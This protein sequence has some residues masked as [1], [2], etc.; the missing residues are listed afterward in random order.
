M[1]QTNIGVAGSPAAL[2]KNLDAVISSTMEKIR[3]KLTDNI[4]TSNAFFHKLMK[5]DQYESYDGGTLISEPL[6]YALADLEAY[7]GYDELVSDPIDGI[8]TA[9][10]PA[11]QVAAPI[12]YNMKE[13]I[14]NKRQIFSLVKAKTT[15]AQMGIEEGFAK[16][17][18]QGSGDGALE[19]PHTNQATGAQSL[20]PVAALIAKD[21]TAAANIGSISQMDNEWWRNVAK[22]FSA[23]NTTNLFMNALNNLYN[24]C[25]LGS[26]GPPNL[27]LM[28][29]LSY[30]Y[31]V[32]AHY[33]KFR[34]DLPTN[35]E[36]PFENKKFKNAMVVMD[37]KVPNYDDNVLDAS[38]ANN[39]SIV[40]FNTKFFKVRYIP[41]RNFE[42]L[43][44]E[45]GNAFQKPLKGDSR[46]GHVAWMGQATVN[47]R[48]KQGLA[49]KV[50]RVA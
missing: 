24:T 29:Q 5:S 45:N 33:D 28:D 3:P 13:A 10:F 15:Q 43:R 30:E 39:G 27:I 50:P 34:A 12:S 36:F 25:A 31:F 7:A 17:F 20:E 40:V 26:G 47:N 11:R 6:M 19:T 1:G 14:E 2:M 48:R 41:E 21:P 37:E 44:D 46:L 4:G 9:L 22:D 42:M 16:H 18:M 35:T 38:G 8:T 49:F 23:A 32:L